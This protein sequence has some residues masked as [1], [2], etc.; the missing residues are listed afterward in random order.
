MDL[1]PAAP[2]AI[3]GRRAFAST[4]PNVSSI[5][6]IAS[7]YQGTYNAMQIVFQRRQNNGLTLSSNYTLAHAVVTNA[8]PWD[9]NVTERYDSGFDVRHRVVL[10]ANYE[11]PFFRSATGLLHGL[12]G[13]WQINTAAFYQTGLTYT[14]TNGTARSNTGVPIG[15][16]RSAIRS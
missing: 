10:L 7:D 4:L 8:A 11:L 16:T 2:G 3:Q 6:L 15:R 5:P 13:D 1:A 14:V 9:V 12:L